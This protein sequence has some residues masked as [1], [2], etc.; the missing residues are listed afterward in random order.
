MLCEDDFI[1][2]P[3][4]QVVVPE[5]SR[6][7]VLKIAHDESGHLGVRETHDRVLRYFSWPK[8]KHDVSKYIKSCHT[9]QLTGKPSQSIKPAPLCPIPAISQ[10]FEHL[11]IDC[12]G[13]LP[14]SKS[15]CSYLL[16][17]MCQT[18]RYPATY[19]VRSIFGKSNS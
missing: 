6:D 19:P 1:G 11:I 17:V 18:T 7:T 2:E 10:P 3:V 12:V 15:G 9:C 14:T 8:L 13:P 16:T 5:K 4:F